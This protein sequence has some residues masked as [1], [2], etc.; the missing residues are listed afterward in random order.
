M[1][2]HLALTKD[3]DSYIDAAH[4]ELQHIRFHLT[5]LEKAKRD[6][7]TEKAT[8]ESALQELEERKRAVDSNVS[9]ELTPRLTTLKEKLSFYRYIIEINKELDVIRAEERTFNSELFEKETEEDPT[10]VKHD[11]NHFFDAETV[12]AFRERL[13]A[14]LEA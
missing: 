11:I 7:A 6:I 14:I 13:I 1:Q 12:Q 4:A 10:E 9:S 2:Y 8:I 5:E 3:T